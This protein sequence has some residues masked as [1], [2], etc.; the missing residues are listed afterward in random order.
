M[1][2]ESNLS[3]EAINFIISLLQ[4]SSNDTHS[5]SSSSFFIARFSLRVAGAVAQD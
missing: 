4:I 2:T 3:T 1:V 5:S